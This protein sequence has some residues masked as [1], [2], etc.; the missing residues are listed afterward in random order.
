MTLQIV[1]NWLIEQQLLLSFLFA[2]LILL[3]R[4]GLPA[5]GA[6]FVYKL[7]WLLPISLIVANLP[8]SLNP[9]PITTITHYLVTPNQAFSSDLNLSWALL[10][11]L[12]TTTLIVFVFTLHFRFVKS[13]QLMALPTSL[14]ASVDKSVKV[15]L[16]NNVTTPM[17]IGILNSKLVLP[18]NYAS[19]YDNNSLA[20]I[21]EHEQVHIKRKDNLINSALLISTLMLWFNPLAWL[22]Y[23]SIRRLQEL[24]CDERVLA[25][26]SAQQHILYSKALIH[27]A[28]NGSAGL[29]AYSHYGDK[30]TMLQRLNN[31]KRNGGRSRLAKGSLLLVAMCMIG[32]LAMA[33]QSDNEMKKTSSV[34][35]IK[36]AEPLYP[37]Q[38]A[39][40]G[41]SGSVVLKY[42]ITATGN[43]SNIRIVSATPENTFEKNAKIALSQWQYKP[44]AD[45]YKDVLVQLDF[46]LGNETEEAGSI[47]RLKVSH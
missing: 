25:N 29:M 19:Q 8:N 35:P 32:G 5:L 18:S 28:T 23:T 45:G 3:E 30:K 24:T 16:S 17:V 31:I 15:Y 39:Q 26:K 22:G 4:F 41:I 44:S 11:L 21:L 1:F 37:V 20:L 6:R 9:M 38:A 43:T 34:T 2:G 7:V 12:I 42:D 14:P 47:E 10:Y 33:K 46:A 27:C 36:R 13:L 40:Q